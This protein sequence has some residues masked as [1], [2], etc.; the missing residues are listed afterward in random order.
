MAL[1]FSGIEP[2]AFGVGDERIV[3]TPVV[4]QELRLRMQEAAKN[5]GTN[6]AGTLDVMAE[7]FPE[8]RVKIR[9]FMEKKM[10]EADLTVLLSYLIGGET[11]TG[12]MKE[13][14]LK[15]EA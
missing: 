1:S 5:A 4:T 3:E 14:L 9:E 12:L 10:T 15:G 2:V 7:A 6:L 8:N 13:R 11:A